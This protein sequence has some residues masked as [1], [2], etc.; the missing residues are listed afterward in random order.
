M[1]AAVAR[2]VHTQE[3]AGSSPVS[4]ILGKIDKRYPTVK[5]WFKEVTSMSLMYLVGF[6]F[7]SAFGFA[8]FMFMHKLHVYIGSPEP[9][10]DG[11]SLLILVCT[12]IF[13]HK[14]SS[15]LEKLGLKIESVLPQMI[16][17]TLCGVGVFMLIL[18][19]DL[20]I[21]SVIEFS[22]DFVYGVFSAN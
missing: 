19:A 7:T 4:A 14:I 10:V 2:L 16:V 8:F 1:V 5:E 15:E 12:L 17:K 18:N 20:V 9:S 3:V 13:Q 11:L 22:N 6:L 21:T